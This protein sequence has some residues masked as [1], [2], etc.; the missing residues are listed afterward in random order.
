LQAEF[1]KTVVACPSRTRQARARAAGLRAPLTF[2]A[3][4]HADIL[5]IV[6]RAGAATV[7]KTDDAAVTRVGLKLLAGV[8]L[9]EKWNPLFDP[10]REGIRAS[11]M[12]LKAR[13]GEWRARSFRRRPL[14][15]GARSCYGDAPP[16]AA[17]PSARALSSRPTN[18]R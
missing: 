17:A 7:L 12:R 14:G 3:A 6:E 4:D 11:I 13:R 18:R 1:G 16:S 2:E 9:K 5:V 8:T 15:G 10:L